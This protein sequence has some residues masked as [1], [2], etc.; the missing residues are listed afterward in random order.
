MQ[1]RIERERLLR[2]LTRVAA[3]AGRGSAPVSSDQSAALACVL[4]TATA[5][6]IS[7]RATNYDLELQSAEE[8]A[9]VTDPGAILVSGKKL[10][11]IARMLPDKSELRVQVQDSKWLDIH[12]DRSRFRLVTLPSY[13][14][15][16]ANF[17]ESGEFSTFTV[18][19]GDL[20]AAM[21]GVVYSIAST[22]TNQ[23]FTGLL[24]Q[25]G[26]QGLRLVAT[27][28]KRLSTRNAP[29]TNYSGEAKTVIVARDSVMHMASMLADGT[30]EVQVQVSASLIR[31]YYRGQRLT[32]KLVAGAFPNFEQVIPKRF[33]ESFVVDRSDFGE[34]VRRAALVIEGDNPLQIRC[35]GGTVELVVDE[36][37]GKQHA[38]CEE[39][40]RFDKLNPF[41]VHVNPRFLSDSVQGGAGASLQM[42]VIDAQSP[43]LLRSPDKHEDFD[44]VMPVR[45]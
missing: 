4:I 26:G 20:A 1:F 7:F 37:K 28:G 41:K 30:D 24:M 36:I 44:I 2:A 32:S 14:Y 11:E 45:A 3:I 13:D 23:A 16:N 21:N 8:P 9:A 33:N 34:A 19:S 17:D 38:A 40:G 39:V 18:S 10:L 35:N 6:G 31:V 43:L 22:H 25:A 5:T 42:L 27:D 29:C 12:S 15:V